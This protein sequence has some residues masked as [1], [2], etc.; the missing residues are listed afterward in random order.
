MRVIIYRCFWAFW[1]SLWLYVSA[2][3]AQTQHAD[4]SSVEWIRVYFNM[5]ADIT[6]VRHIRKVL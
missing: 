1:L 5:P 3:I 6:V 2:G 4:T